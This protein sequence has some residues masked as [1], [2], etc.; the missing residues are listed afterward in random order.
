MTDPVAV[1]TAMS[2]RE[3]EITDELQPLENYNTMDAMDGVDLSA[4]CGGNTFNMMLNTKAEF[5]DDVHLRKAIAYCPVLTTPAPP[6][7]AMWRRPRRSW[8]SP[9]MRGRA[10]P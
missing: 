1:R 2:N 3:L 10:S 4:V 9:N 5:T 8:P 6:I 7:P